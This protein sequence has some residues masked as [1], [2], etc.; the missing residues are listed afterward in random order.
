MLASYFGLAQISPSADFSATLACLDPFQQQRLDAIQNPQRRAQFLSARQLAQ[1][2]LKTSQTEST[3]SQHDNGRPWAPAWSHPAGLSWSH[4]AQFCAAA[5]GHGRVGIDIETIRPRKQLMAI[6]ESYF[7]SRESAWLASLAGEAQLRAFF[8][9]WVAKEALLKAFGTGLVGGLQ[10][11]VL[12]QTD[13]GWCCDSPEDFDW[14]LSI[15]EVS[16]NVLLAL[17]SDV[18]QEW[19]CHGEQQPWQLILKV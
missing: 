1:Q 11:F 6:A 10:R 19:I 5:L 17:A 14:S 12:R 8:M 7:D 9:L 18:K 16:P 3:L 4:G 15:W 2:L 13:A